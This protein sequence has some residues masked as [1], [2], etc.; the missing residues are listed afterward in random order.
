MLQGGSS[1][2]A[3]NHRERGLR[4]ECLRGDPAPAIGDRLINGQN[5]A[6]KTQS[7]LMV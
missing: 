6:R 4:G 1:K 3:V 7:E 5:A 2:K